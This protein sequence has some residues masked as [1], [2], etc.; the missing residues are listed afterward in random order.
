MIQSTYSMADISGAIY[1]PPTGWIQMN[2]KGCDSVRVAM[3]E[4]QTVQEVSADGAV[5]SS[6]ILN[7]SG[8]LTLV[9]QLNSALE[10]AL[11]LS[12]DSAK[13]SPTTVWCQGVALIRNVG[14]GVSHSFTG[15]SF[16]KVPDTTY[17]KVAG[18]VEWSFFAAD[19]KHIVT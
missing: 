10:S 7:D 19:I 9:V 17:T 8:K 12:Y 4:S 13:I 2:G 11:I 16:D 5:Q 1:L 14:S 15:L 3:N 18:L 6:K